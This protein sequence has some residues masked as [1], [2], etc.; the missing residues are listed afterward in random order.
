M[1]RELV[2]RTT[3]EGLCRSIPVPKWPPPFQNPA[4]QTAQPAAR[5]GIVTNMS[6]NRRNTRRWPEIVAPEGKLKWAGGQ[7]PVRVTDQSSEGLG[8]ELPQGRHLQAGD[9]VWLRT[10][11]GVTEGIVMHVEPGGA[12]NHVGMARLRDFVPADVPRWRWWLGLGPT[13]KAGDWR[14]HNL[15]PSPAVWGLFALFVAGLIGYAA[16]R[17]PTAWHRLKGLFVRNVAQHA[18]ASAP[19]AG[20]G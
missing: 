5:Q 3:I 15:A 12:A 8:L 1:P 14:R 10:C 18:T 9:H 4:R 17:D 11:S 6:E 2:F 19:P 20:N 13:P 16:H 7:A